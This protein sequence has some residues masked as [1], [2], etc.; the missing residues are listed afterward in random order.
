[1]VWVYYAGQIFFFGAELA[2][3]YARRRAARKAV[4]ER[5]G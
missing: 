2:Q 1:M 3:A 4:P 5:R